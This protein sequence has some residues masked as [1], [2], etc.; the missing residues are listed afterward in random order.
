MNDMNRS[1]C[2][3][4]LYLIGEFLAQLLF[5]LLF[6]VVLVSFDKVRCSYVYTTNFIHSFDN[7]NNNMKF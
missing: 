3:L 6:F 7:L 1:S 2:F 5:M 4:F